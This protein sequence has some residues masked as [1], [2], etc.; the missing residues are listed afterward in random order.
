MHVASFVISGASV[1]AARPR[2]ADLKG[3]GPRLMER[4]EERWPQLENDPE[5]RAN[6]YLLTEIEPIGWRSADDAAREV[7]GIAPDSPF[8][9]EAAASHVLMVEGEQKGH[10]ALAPRKVAFHLT[11]LL[12]FPMPSNTV[13]PGDRVQL[14]DGLF[15]RART[16]SAET[17]VAACLR[18]MMERGRPSFDLHF[19]DAGL[20]DDQRAALKLTRYFRCFILC[21]GPGTG[22]TTTIRALISRSS[23]DDI[24]LCATTG[25]AASRMRELTGRP[26]CT[27]H[28]LLRSTRTAEGKPAFSHGF[29][30]IHHRD[31]PL[32]YKLVVVDETSMANICI[33]ADLLSALRDDAMLVIVGDTFQLPSVGAGAFLRDAIAG[34]VPY[35]ELTELKR[36]DPRLMI[37]HN[38][39]LIRFA[40]KIDLNN[41]PDSDF[42]FIPCSDPARIR[43][44]VVE[45]M[46]DR[47]PR[48]Y[49]FD[50]MRDIVALMRR[51]GTS[52]NSAG[53]IE[54]S[55][56]RPTQPQVFRRPLI[57]AR[58]SGHPAPQRLRPR[59]HERRAGSSPAAAA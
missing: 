37:H 36:Q 38:C 4:I 33:M 50:S 46:T 28:T 45:Y 26:A 44:L 54:Q 7:F 58:R 43:E 32:P 31:N 5:L 9:I 48:E 47:L 24:A 30:F 59:R 18:E 12:G 10:T 53:K 39:K 27:I 1:T 57:H 52:A 25:K 34:G 41:R 51:A 16:L 20:A 42:L 23:A 56:A 49:G 2:L 55:P 6:P 11:A 22:K 40:R 13:I 21:G 19:D 15:S 8:R 14:V 29:R 3:F 35:V 17:V